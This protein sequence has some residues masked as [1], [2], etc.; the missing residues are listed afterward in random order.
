MSKDPGAS[1]PGHMLQPPYASVSSSVKRTAG[2]LQGLREAAP[3]VRASCMPKWDHT[4]TPGSGL[5]HAMLG[6]TGSERLHSQPQG[7]RAHEGE[8]GDHT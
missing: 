3:Q 5:L 8:S 7:H 6:G 2:L 4:H 1:K